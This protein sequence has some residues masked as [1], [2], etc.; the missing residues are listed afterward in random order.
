MAC[1]AIERMASFSVGDLV[2]LMWGA[3][4]LRKGL[5]PHSGMFRSFLKAWTA[6]LEGR[7]EELDLE[8]TR[9]VRGHGRRERHAQGPCPVQRSSKNL[10]ALIGH[11]PRVP[12]PPL[13]S[14]HRDGLAAL[15]TALGGGAHGQCKGGS[16]ARCWI[17]C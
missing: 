12:P 15:T 3:S 7:V 16:C 14:C 9:R 10:V 8:Q 11:P 17:G 5:L 2:A 6:E 1:G 4:Q 13:V